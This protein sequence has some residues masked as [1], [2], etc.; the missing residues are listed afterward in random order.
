M[1]VPT[2]SLILLL[3]STLKV[4]GILE[5]HICALEI[6]P[7][8]PDQVFPVMDLDGREVLKPSSS[9]VK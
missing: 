2:H 8:N 5:A 7:K 3:S 4:T 9:E 1:D 6:P